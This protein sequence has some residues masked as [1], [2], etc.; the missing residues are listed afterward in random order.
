[1]HGFYRY[2]APHGGHWSSAIMV[3]AI[4]LCK[5]LYVSA[6]R[7]INWPKSTCDLV[8]INCTTLS[9]LVTSHSIGT[10]VFQFLLNSSNDIK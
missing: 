5:V 2:G 10:H 8:C 7:I 6:V 4:I 1:M 9:A 3:L